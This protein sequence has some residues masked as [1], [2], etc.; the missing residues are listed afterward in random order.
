MASKP[1]LDNNFS[2][3]GYGVVE[4]RHTDTLPRN[5]IVFM[6]EF[7]L[8]KI[9]EWKV[10]APDDTLGPRSGFQ[11]LIEGIGKVALQ[12]SRLNSH[13][14]WFGDNLVFPIRKQDEVESAVV[15]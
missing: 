9:S 14:V 10:W 12:T 1:P 15:Q 3:G 7:Q 8:S 2:D 11:D 4:Y 6:I 13:S 5:D